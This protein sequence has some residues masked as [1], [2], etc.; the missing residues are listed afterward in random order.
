MKP[1]EIK[2]GEILGMSL[3]QNK[4]IT[5]LNIAI[6]DDSIGYNVSTENN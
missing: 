6:N 3:L 4:E 2:A 5:K 1:V